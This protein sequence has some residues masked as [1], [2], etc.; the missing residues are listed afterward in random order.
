MQPTAVVVEDEA[1][2]G[3]LIATVLESSG[4]RVH[5]AADGLAAVELIRDVAPD[6]ITLDIGIPGIDGIEVARRVRAFS[7]AYV[8]FISAL[9]E[10][11]DAERA[12]AAGGDEYL[13]KPFRP[14][15]L[16][17]RVA[18]IPARHAA[19]GFSTAPDVSGLRSGS[20]R[21]GEQNG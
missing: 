16:R 13:G 8:I 17:A 2:I 3:G 11:A 4:Y 12:R 20:D 10:P 15:D 6:L 5:T 7:D 14:R 9:S 19:E 1:D 18:H 21:L